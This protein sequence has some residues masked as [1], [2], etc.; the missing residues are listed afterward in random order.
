M[1][2]AKSQSNREFRA[3]LQSGLPDELRRS[4]PISYGKDY[5]PTKDKG[6]R[7]KPRVPK[8]PRWNP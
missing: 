6:R 4:K 8:V 7:S 5:Q 3:R 1:A 2:G